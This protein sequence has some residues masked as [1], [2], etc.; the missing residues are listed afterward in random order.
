MPFL[1]AAIPALIGVGGSIAGGLL[2][3]KSKPVGTNPD[4]PL[5]K[6]QLEIANMGQS[7]AAQDIP[8]ARNA[9]EL[10]L[11]YWKRILTGGRYPALEELSPETQTITSQ[12]DS[13]LRNNSQFAPRGGGTSAQNEELRFKRAADI[14]NLLLKAR[15]AAASNIQKIGEDY[16]S[17][18]QGEL[19][20]AAAAAHGAAST[21][22]DLAA[23]Q[24]RRDAEDAA[25]RSAMFN[26]I[27]SG[28]GDVIS[29]LLKGKKGGGGTSTSIPGTPGGGSDPF[30][31]ATG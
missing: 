29:V 8:T 14:T 2:S 13:A 24:A 7:G 19:S 18:G 22:T 20:S 21:A 26:D 4:D 30:D 27:G 11:N 23:I 16:A 28:L 17:L 9:L 31:T 15:P 12:Y 3:K 25:A 5:V 6:K 10:P 1:A